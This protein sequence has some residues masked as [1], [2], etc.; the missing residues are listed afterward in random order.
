MTPNRQQVEAS[1]GSEVIGQDRINTVLCR[2]GRK[3]LRLWWRFSGNTL[4]Q[5]PNSAN[6]ALTALLPLAMHEGADLHVRGTVDRTLLE[7]LEEAIDA[8]TLW[9]PDLYRPI[10]ISAD[11]VTCATYE[12]EARAALMYSGGV[13]AN[14]ALVAHKERLLGHRNRDVGTAVLVHGF[15][16]PLSEEQWFAQAKQH[17]EPIL[18]HFDCPLTVVQTN[19]RSISVN[20]EM[21]FGFGVTT[22]LHQLERDHGS[23]LWA[24]D[25]PY[26]REVI[27]WGSN[28]ISNPLLSGGTFPIRCVG[29]GISRAGKIGVIGQ[30]PIIREHLRVCWRRPQNGQNCGVCE[31][32]VRTRLALQAYGYGDTPAFQGVLAP[33]MVSKVRIDSA[34]QF[35]LMDEVRTVPDS[36]L[37]PEL[38]KALN[39]RLSQ[40][41]QREQDQHRW[42]WP[43]RGH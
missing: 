32:C 31:K 21:A 39:T 40:Y 11:E 6:H 26:N 35:D 14:Y 3:E 28:S 2:H 27:P 25:E 22:V 19:W 17:A 42:W 18:D 10:R 43:F 33:D 34:V 24:A 16:I 41:Q 29:S 12:P 20:W 4:V 8:W 30:H 36:R 37:S 38:Q 13:D 1:V 5:P 15:D 7:N 23:G 9:R